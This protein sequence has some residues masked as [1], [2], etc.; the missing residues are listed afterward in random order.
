MRSLLALAAVATL[1]A[2]CSG[3]AEPEII[4]APT[5]ATPSPAYDPTLEPAAAVMAV[6]PGDATTLSVTDFD[7]ARF[8]LGY[9]DLS[10][11]ADPA[12]RRRFWT[13]ATRR[14]ALLSDG[15]FRVDG[16]TPRR[17]GFTQDDVAWEA[18]F[19]GPSGDGL[20]V[21]FHDDLDM[22]LVQRSARTA[23]SPIE[24]A[25]VVPAAHLA[26]IGATREPDES[27]AAD[28]AL[29]ALVGQKAVAT[30]V[31]RSCLTVEEAFGA[32]AADDLAPTPAADLDDLVELSSFSVS[33]GGTLVTARLGAPRS[34]VFE[35]ARLAAT[36]PA[37]E[38]EFGE[39]F[40]D[41]VADPAG[42]RI[43]FRLGDGPVAARLVEERQLPFAVC[44]G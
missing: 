15:V 35:R 19:A 11:E 25:V 17:N 28:P 34:D 24:G 7:Q 23:G 29:T 2:G 26:A 3:D 36:M 42:G 8:S 10:S 1:L 20:V 31:S 6:V 27:W 9:G 18:S 32:D 30:Y 12:V 41:P 21:R 39:G 43:G 16:E 22:R 13:E 33:L 37:T 40:S 14:S 5:V 4:G 44:G 38:P